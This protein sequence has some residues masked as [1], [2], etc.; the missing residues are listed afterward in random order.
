MPPVEGIFFNGQIY[1]AYAFVSD[2]I[3]SADKRII[4]IDNY[5]GG[6]PDRVGHDGK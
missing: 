3:R 2:L 6:M 4:L 5:N 1:D